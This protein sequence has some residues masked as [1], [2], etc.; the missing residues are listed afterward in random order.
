MPGLS[1]VK[2]IGE[3][4]YPVIKEG[5]ILYII[6]TKNID[7]GDIVVFQKGDMQIA[8]RVV[9]I[10]GDSITTK[11]D[12]QLENDPYTVSYDELLGKVVC[13]AKPDGT[14]INLE[15]VKQSKLARNFRQNIVNFAGKIG[16]I[17]FFATLIDCFSPLIICSKG[18]AAELN[19]KRDVFYNSSGFSK[20]Q[21]C[22]NFYMFNI[23][24]ASVLRFSDRGDLIY[25][26]S[27]FSG[28]SRIKG[29]IHRYC[30]FG[31]FHPRKHRI[32]SESQGNR[33]ESGG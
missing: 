25:I 14:V 3:S 1:A 9:K 4:M 6:N 17:R 33:R 8:H 27:L 31:K 18:P 29:L 5:D 16:N 11:P 23:P 2:V 22:F 30:N 20:P 19:F 12:S 26:R 10:S 7:E 32:Y 21:N 28:S 13:A 15:P 24:V